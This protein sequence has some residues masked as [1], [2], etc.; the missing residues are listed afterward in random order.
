MKGGFLGL[1]IWVS[2]L[3]VGLGVGFLAIAGNLTIPFIPLMVIQIAGWIL[4]ISTILGT[5]MT[6]MKNFR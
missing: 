3:L 5:V 2:A 6:I 1:L 4:V